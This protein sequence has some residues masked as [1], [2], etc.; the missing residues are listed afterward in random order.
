M[1]GPDRQFDP[2]ANSALGAVR[3]SNRTLREAQKQGPLPEIP[4]QAQLQRNVRD[5]IKSVSSFSP[6]N[7][8]AGEGNI[9]SPFGDDGPSSPEG[10][11]DPA[12]MLPDDAPTPDSF[13]PDALLAPLNDSPL[14]TPGQGNG[15]PSPTPGSGSGSSA[16]DSSGGSGNTATPNRGGGQTR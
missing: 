11:P 16:S 2:V 12:A 4:Q 6:F 10:V 5:G 8:L 15:A 13:L 14:P 9:P 1:A 7:V 3:A